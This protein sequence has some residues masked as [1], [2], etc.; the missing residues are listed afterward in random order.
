MADYVAVGQRAITRPQRN[1]DKFVADYAAGFD[2]GEGLV[3]D[4]DAIIDMQRDVR[5]IILQCNRRDLADPDARDLHLIAAFET[6]NIVEVGVER[7]ARRREDLDAT[8]P[9]RKENEPG[10]TGEGENS[11][12]KLGEAAGVH[13]ILT[14]AGG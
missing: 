14:F 4:L 9:D 1:R 3:V 8:E 6:R 5:P 11:D 13:L 2:R 7:I 12:E 10:D